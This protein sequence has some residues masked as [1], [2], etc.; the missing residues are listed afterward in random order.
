MKKRTAF[1]FVLKEFPRV[2]QTVSALL[3][4][5]ITNL[6]YFKRIERSYLTAFP[7]VFKDIAES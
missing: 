6:F 2:C 3:L 4:T 1:P 7:V 5:Y